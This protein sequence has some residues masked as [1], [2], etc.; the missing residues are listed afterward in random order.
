ME[1]FGWIMTIILGALAGWIAERIMKGDHTLLLNIVLGIVGA[2]L[3]N[4]L[5]RLLF[6]ATLG[7]II[8]QLIVAVIGAVI[9]IWLVRAISG[10]S[11]A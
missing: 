9:L 2:L 5:F 1:G 4:W 10:R 11:R 3:G 6:D 7:G 8:G